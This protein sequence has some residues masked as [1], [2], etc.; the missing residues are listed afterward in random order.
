MK[1]IAVW[2]TAFLGDAVLT[3]PLVQSLKLAYPDTS[4]DFYVRSG[5]APLFEAHPDIDSVYSFNKSSSG[6]KW[7]QT[8]AARN[9]YAERGYGLWVCAHPG[10]RSGLMARLSQASARIGYSEVPFS[11]M[12][13]TRRVSRHFSRLE[14]VERLLELLRPLGVAP[15]STK[16][17]IHLPEPALHAAG[18]F[19]SSLQES[20]ASAPVLGLH[21][22]SVW[23]TKR[24]PARYFAQ[25][26]Q[27]ALESGAVLVLFAGP[28]EDAVALEVLETLETL[29]SPEAMGRVY[30]LS[31]RL[32]L[33]ELAAY[34][35]RLSCYITN[36][37]GP[38]HLAWAQDVPTAALFGPTVKALGFYPRGKESKV[39][40]IS[41]DCRP[42]GR[43][44]HGVCPQKHHHCMEKLLP[45]MV[46][47][48]VAEKLEAGY[49]NCGVTIAKSN[50]EGI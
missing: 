45:E 18:I 12:W 36:D 8:F 44:G 16:P 27:M 37:S 48:Y 23:A 40:E 30:D 42:C 3:L 50:T 22:G 34:I 15:A 38:M 5:F 39:F 41:L 9:E 43:H 13:F 32:S 6:A 29:V 46:W 47:P 1:R 33:V 26:G 11:A 4:L 28:G 25:V 20:H 19:F 35:G 7:R 14:E 24:W 31:C 10:L 2:N 17:E 49:K 21:P